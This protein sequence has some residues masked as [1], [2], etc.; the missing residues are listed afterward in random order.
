MKY[1]KIQ[2]LFILAFSALTWTA[3]DKIDEPVKIINVQDIPDNLADTLF[4]TD[5]VWVAQKQV[6]LEE[7]TG[8][9][10]VNCAEQSIAAHELSEEND[11]RLVI[12]SIH[13][14]FYAQVDETG[15]YTTDHT[16]ATGI[17]IFQNFLEPFNPTA[18]IDRV[19]YNGSQVIFPNLWVTVFEQELAKENVANMLVKNSWYPN[20]SSVLIEVNTTFLQNLEG[21]YKLVVMIAEDH[22]T[23]PQKNNNSAIGPTP[24]WLDYDHRNI[25]RDAITPV[26][27]SYITA[28]GT[29]VANEVYTNTFFYAPNAD[30]TTSNCNIIAYIIHEE[31]GE[32]IQ[33]AE[34]G[35]KTTE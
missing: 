21:K 23:A 27:G 5:S 17:K 35:I 22:V 11:H 30:W 24:D 6:L 12:Y 15:D 19:D 14:G 33:T 7:F 13:A 29:I 31:T 10:C 3:C 18:T 2:I 16:S 1:N 9:K 26:F 25:L 34:L 8:H 20:L 4:F 32:V 28:D